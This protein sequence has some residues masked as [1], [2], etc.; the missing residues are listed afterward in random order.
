MIYISSD[1]GGFKLK[2]RLLKHFEDSNIEITDLGPYEYIEND[3]YPDYVDPLVK[4]VLESTENK[5]ILI[6][7][8]GVGVCIAANKHKGIR[9]A[10][11]WNKKHAK[12]SRTDDNSNIL[13][14]PADYINLKRAKNIVHAWRNTPFSGLE[15]HIRR[16]SKL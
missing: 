8:N 1:H 10:L 16:I 7:R 4:K 13:C 11:S 2:E 14:L 9:A 6:C 3:D 5:G 12:S 15:R